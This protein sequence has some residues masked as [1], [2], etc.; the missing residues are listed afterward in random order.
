M[1]GDPL[2]PVRNTDFY[3][4]VADLRCRENHG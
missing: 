3:P 4:R 2:R 1:A